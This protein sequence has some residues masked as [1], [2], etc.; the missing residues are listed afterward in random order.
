MLLR[1]IWLLDNDNYWEKIQAEGH[2]NSLSL[3]CIFLVF[4]LLFTC[5]HLFWL[6]THHILLHMILYYVCV[7]P[8]FMKSPIHE[9]HVEG[10]TC[11]SYKSGPWSFESWLCPFHS[12]SIYNASIL[13]IYKKYKL[14]QINS[15]CV[16]WHW[17]I[18]V[19]INT[20]LQSLSHL[21]DFLQW[22]KNVFSQF[23]FYRDTINVCNMLWWFV[24]NYISVDYWSI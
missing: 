17:F 14:V 15:L 5:H 4:L 16:V 23:A 6:F 13:Q 20:I 11:Y 9:W 19:L 3:Q 24:C 18:L 7:F 8:S 1:L 22:L 21:D 2:A 10:S 12:T